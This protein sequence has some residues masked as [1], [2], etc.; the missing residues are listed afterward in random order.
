[1]T[2][3]LKKRKSLDK[4]RRS[5]KGTRT[6]I[7]EA[8]QLRFSHYGYEHVGVRDIGA[9][10]NVDAALIN[11][12]FGTKEELFAETTKGI[13]NGSHFIDVDPSKIGEALARRL[14]GGSKGK[15]KGIDPFEF[16][17]RSA[18]NPTASPIIA[19]RLHQDFVVYLAAVI[20]GKNATTR[21]A[22]ITSYIVGFLTVRVALKSPA[23]LPAHADQVIAL[24]GSAIQA[25]VDRNK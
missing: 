21:A 12:Y 13:F 9:D 15:K 3:P 23:L 19:D 5:A 14:M 8:A 16:L 2:A 18:A 10:A 22:L 7:L 11:R 4:P 24:L 17:L 25:A 20:G 1:M 6:R